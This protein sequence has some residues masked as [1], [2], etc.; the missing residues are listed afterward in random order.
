MEHLS[1]IVFATLGV[2]AGLLFGRFVIKPMIEKR[3]YNK[4]YKNRKNNKRA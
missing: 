3:T 2:A 4:K 1:S